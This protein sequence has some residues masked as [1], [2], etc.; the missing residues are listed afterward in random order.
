MRLFSIMA[1]F[2]MAALAQ[3]TRPDSI[4]AYVAREM[5]TRRIP[6]AAVA[7]VE[8][9]AVTFKK[10]YGVANLET[11][12]PVR[13]NSVFQLASLT[14]QFT[15]AAIMMLVE[16]GKVKLDA[17]IS[18]YIENTPASWSAVTVRHLLTHTGGITPGAIVRVD[19]TPLIDITAARA[20]DF[21]SKAPMVFRPGEGAFY[22]DTG[23]FLLGLIIQ[24]ASGQ[25]YR[26]FMQKRVFDR[27][28]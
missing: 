5:Q 9:G 11:D 8:H 17:P 7:V 3:G 24:K 16:E 22:S 26:D 20:L 10:G 1:A 27:C 13:T 15:G 2:T 18:A 21:V 14:K 23:F 28:I 12:T 6:G 4:D 25:P 19:G